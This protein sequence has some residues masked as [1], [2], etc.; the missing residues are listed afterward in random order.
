MNRLLQ[1]LVLFLRDNRGYGAAGA[2]IGAVIS[3][4]LVFYVVS[5]TYQP[6]ETAAV[7]LQDALNQSQIQGVS[8]L[9]TLPGVAVLLFIL[10]V[11]FGIIIM[12]VR[13]SEV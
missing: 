3:F 4:I 1:G 7:T 11:I 2:I 9:A 13:G 5:S 8:D 10:V 12:A 6:M